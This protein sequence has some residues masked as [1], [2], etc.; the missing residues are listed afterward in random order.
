MFLGSS[1]K[2]VLGKVA[3]WRRVALC[4]ASEVRSVAV[5][6]D[7][8]AVGQEA[9]VLYSPLPKWMCKWKSFKFV[10]FKYGRCLVVQVQYSQLPLLAGEKFGVS[11]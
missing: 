7:Q 6:V 5:V 11:R 2:Y 10:A 8:V 1:V 4:P 9:T 3:K